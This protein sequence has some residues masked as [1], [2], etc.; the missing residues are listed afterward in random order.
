MHRG[1]QYF[2]KVRLIKTACFQNIGCDTI[3]RAL[4]E[5]AWKRQI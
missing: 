2:T 4:W 5:I 1:K 3:Q